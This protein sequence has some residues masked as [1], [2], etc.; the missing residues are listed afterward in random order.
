MNINK[1]LE[2]TVKENV[3]DVHLTAGSSPIMRKNGK[4]IRVDSKKLMPDDLVSIAKEILSEKEIETLEE[5]GAIDV[6]YSISHIGRFRVNIYIQRGSYAIAIRVVALEI[7]TIDSLGLPEIIK[8]LAMMKRGLILV[9][10]PTGSGKSTTLAAMINYMNKH[11]NEHIITIEDPIEFLHKHEKCIINQREIGNDT[12]SFSSALRSSL[13]QDPDIILVGEMRDLD[14]ISTAITAAETGHLVLSTVHTIGA[15]STIERI[16]DVFPPYQQQ[17]IK[18]QLSSVLQGVISQQIMP[19]A[20]GEGR[21][22][23]FE[24]MK[25]ITAIRNL[26]REGKSHQLQTVIQTNSRLGM[27]TMDASLIDLYNAREITKET[28]LRYSVDKKAVKR[29][30]GDYV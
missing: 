11:R 30:I 13:R 15:A 20:V 1:I 26:I 4:L 25:S 29:R 9:T 7:P 12:F 14:T 10:G 21:V 2:D 19:K 22:A 6:A 5:E 27:I 18:L 23:A 3:S 28:L 17:Q 16:V 8:D 24:I